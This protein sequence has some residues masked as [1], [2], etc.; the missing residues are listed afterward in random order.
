MFNKLVTM[1]FKVWTG[2][3]GVMQVYKTITHQT[4]NTV[5]YVEIT[6]FF[7]DHHIR[8]VWYERTV[9]HNAVD[10]NG[11]WIGSALID[12]THVIT[13]LFPER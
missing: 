7:D 8:S 9:Y 6:Y 4:G 11:L 12:K 13:R 3:N 2:K 5:V 1:G 10:A